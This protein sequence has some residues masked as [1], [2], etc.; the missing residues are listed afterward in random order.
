MPFC[1][2]SFFTKILLLSPK[3]CQFCS[4]GW[5]FDEWAIKTIH[6][7][8]AL[9]QR[10]AKVKVDMG[11]KLVLNSLSCAQGFLIQSYPI[12]RPLPRVFM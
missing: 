5:K 1:L 7:I 12:C 4:N 2:A 11:S 10:K 6:T 9:Y 3:V 8:V